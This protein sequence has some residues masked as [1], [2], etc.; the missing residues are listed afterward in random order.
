MKAVVL[1]IKDG[2]AAVLREDSI[3]VKYTGPCEVGDTVEVPGGTASGL[4]VLSARMTKIAAGTAAAIAA[5]SG[6]GWYGYAYASPAAYV[7]M[8]IN[9][10]F[11]MALNRQDQVLKIEA[12]NSDAAAIVEEYNERHKKRESLGDAV[13][14]VTEILYEESYLGNG[15][16]VSINAAS[17]NEEK[18]LHLTEEAKVAVERVAESHN[19]SAIVNLTTATKEERKIAREEGISTGAY[20]EKEAG[21]AEQKNPPSEEIPLRD[22]KESEQVSDNPP[23]EPSQDNKQP[24]D[25]DNRSETVPSQQLV[26]EEDGKVPSE[27]KPMPPSEGQPSGDNKEI[28]R[29]SGQGS[30]ERPS[31]PNR[32][33]G[34]TPQDMQTPPGNETAPNPVSPDADGKPD[35]NTGG[36]GAA[37]SDGQPKQ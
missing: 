30:E 2:V 8:D 5:L 18:N 23:K 31:E 27:E 22:N 12:I 11:E 21:N 24:A 9:P 34:Q 16:D 29:E 10:S 19:D 3:V 33:E 15:N 1:E 6:F 7:S 13:E 32:P 17:D 20:V 36:M 14:L 28:I 26:P 35:V 25:G 37:P 4:K